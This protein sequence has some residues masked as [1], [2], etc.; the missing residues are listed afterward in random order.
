VTGQERRWLKRFGPA[1]L[2]PRIQLL[3]FHFAG[4]NAGSF[5]H[6]PAM[7]PWDVE[8]T[9]VQLPGRADRF[10]EPAFERMQPLVDALIDVT[11]SLRGSPF[12]CYGVSMGAR[13]AWAMAHA[14]RERALPAPRA[15][16]LSASGGP[17]RDDGNWRWEGRSDGLAGYVKEMGGT[18]P[19]VLAEPALL[20]ALLPTLRA[21][22]TV[23]ST[24]GFH[25]AVP[26]DTPIRAFAGADD[27]EAT[28][29]RMG[30]WADET[31]AEFALETYACGHFFDGNAERAMVSAISKD[32]NST[33]C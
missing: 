21:D 12:A 2:N 9:A 7:L 11:A 33:A 29:D 27:D 32:L 5:R 13:V 18:P 8:L 19:E 14:L 23:L 3:C 30:A 16:Y 24:H 17:R 25:P 6:W 31:T 10:G 22:L 28:P 1:R 4:G 15:L 20:A 26:L